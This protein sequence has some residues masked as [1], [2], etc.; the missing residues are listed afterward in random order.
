M[1][2]DGSGAGAEEHFADL[3]DPPYWAVTFVNRFRP[4]LTPGEL[5]DYNAD[6]DRML[7]LAAKI[8]GYLG[9]TSVRDAQGRAVSVSYWT[10]EDAIRA[11]REDVEHTLTRARG[12]RHWYGAYQVQVSRVDRA[13]EWRCCAEAEAEADA[14]AGG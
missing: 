13:Y 8:P 10:G 12:R 9:F 7:D 1:S 2:G 11:W 5:A 6:A 4:G 14:D 3:P